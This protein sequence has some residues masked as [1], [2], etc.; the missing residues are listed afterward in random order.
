MTTFTRNDINVISASPQQSWVN[1][2]TRGFFLCW[3]EDT[4]NALTV[5]CMWVFIVCWFATCKLLTERTLCMLLCRH[6]C[7]SSG[8]GDCWYLVI[9]CW[10]LWHGCVW[11]FG[12]SWSLFLWFLAQ[13]CLPIP[14]CELFS[15]EYH[16]H[17][18]RC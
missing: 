10:H 14:N 17:W 12:L 18:M 16:T 13:N 8:C 15:T 7:V 5:D 1:D 2:N 11:I 9:F 4:D 3:N 6:I